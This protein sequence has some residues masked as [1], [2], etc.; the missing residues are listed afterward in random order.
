M[1]LKIDGKEFSV[2]IFP[3]EIGYVI[4]VNNKKIKA[5]ETDEGISVRDKRITYIRKTT[6]HMYKVCVNHD[7]FHV[8]LMDVSAR[9]RH[10]V[11]SPMQG[12]IM[13]VDVKKGQK[14]EEGQTMVK[15]ISMKM[16]NE[17]KAEKRC[18]VKEVRVKDK[19]DIEKGD[20]LIEL[21]K[22]G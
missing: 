5:S 4:S 13:S 11:K 20:V 16:E 14:V 6:D 18:I 22:D 17:I 8:E 9:F 3:D 19:Q 15:F 12:T 7:Q 21:E 10:I 2:S 1:K